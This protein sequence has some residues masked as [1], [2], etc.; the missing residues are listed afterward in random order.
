MIINCPNCK[1]KFKIDDNLIPLEGRDLQCGSCSQI[2][3]YEKKK[4]LQ[5]HIISIRIS[6]IP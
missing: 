5:K 2:W 6:V 4:Y 3:F 1:K